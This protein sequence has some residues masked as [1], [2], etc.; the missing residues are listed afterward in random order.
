MITTKPTIKDL[1]NG[2]PLMCPI[3]ERP[4]YFPS[5]H[6][7]VPRSRGGKSTETIC[8]D[9][10]KAEGRYQSEE[11]AKEVDNGVIN[12]LN[13]LKV[14]YCVSRPDEKDLQLTLGAIKLMR[15]NFLNK[16]PLAV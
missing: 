14:D 12:F 5:D 15:A 1:V 7:M 2:P 11:Q 16:V 9:C 8:A 6:H 3:C 4:N 10:H 13:N